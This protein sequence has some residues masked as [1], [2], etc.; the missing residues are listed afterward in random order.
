[1]LLPASES[2]LSLLET[3]HS[4]GTGRDILIRVSHSTSWRRDHER[5]HPRQNPTVI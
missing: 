3:P 4:R 1:M 2:A 5:F